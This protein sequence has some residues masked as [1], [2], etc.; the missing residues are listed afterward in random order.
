[1]TAFT[2]GLVE[3]LSPWAKFQ[4]TG[5]PF[6]VG[7]DPDTFVDDGFEE[8]GKI[9]D[10]FEMVEEIV[11]RV[12]FMGILQL[13]LYEA[14]SLVASQTSGDGSLQSVHLPCSYFSVSRGFCCQTLSRVLR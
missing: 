10:A 1:M 2:Q 4:H 6:L 5:L 9:T 11:P 8:Y 13:F 3:V 7:V 14:S 12:I